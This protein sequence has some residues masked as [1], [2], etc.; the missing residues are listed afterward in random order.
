ML[1]TWIEA[2]KQRPIGFQ[3]GRGSLEL[4]KQYAKRRHREN[5]KITDG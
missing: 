5:E 4:W 2:S 3:E 1:P